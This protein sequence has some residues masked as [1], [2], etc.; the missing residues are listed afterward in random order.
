MRSIIDAITTAARKPLTWLVGV[1]AV[2]VAVVLCVVF[3]GD[4]VNFF[5]AAP[6]FLADLARTIVT[7]TINGVGSL[8]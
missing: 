6:T 5:L 1:P 3:G 7:T 2:I 8:F 4:I